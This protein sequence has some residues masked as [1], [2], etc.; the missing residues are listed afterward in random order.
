MNKLQLDYRR[1]ARLPMPGLILLS[2]SIVLSILVWD[3][4]QGLTL[5]I[6]DWEDSLNRFEQAS[7]QQVK[8]A[9]LD[10]RGA[11]LDLKQTSEVLRQIMLPWESLF[12]AVESA[13]YP[14]VTLLGLEPD[15]EKHTVNIS[16]EAKDMGAMLKFIKRLKERQEFGS[17]YLQSHQIQERDPEKPVRFSLIAFWRTN[18]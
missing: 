12:Q 5:K 10:A 4:Y 18:L 9:D 17:V 14:E 11:S 15:L 8:G 2:I 16:C 3:Y 13:I 6:E 7:G 1:N